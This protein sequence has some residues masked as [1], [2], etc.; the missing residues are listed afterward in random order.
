MTIENG[1]ER[2]RDKTEQ[3]SRVL[4]KDRGEE[5]KSEQKLVSKTEKSKQG[6]KKKPE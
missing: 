4:E 2:Q 5:E 1:S 3:E 6:E